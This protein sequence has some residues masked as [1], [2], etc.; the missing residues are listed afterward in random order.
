MSTPVTINGLIVGKVTNIDFA[1]INGS[2]I[3]KFS[4]EKDFEFSKNSEVQI[5]SSGII[6]GNNLGIIPKKDSAR[7]AVSGDTLKGVIQAGLIDGLM[8]K[9]KP[10]ET[11]LL[12][13][14]A[15]LDTVLVSISEVM[16]EETK[17]NLKSSIANLNQTM[18]SFK[19]MSQNMNSL[20]NSN[21]DKLNN[22]FTNL[23]ITAANFARLSDSLAQI[24]TGELVKNMEATLSKLNSIA[25]G[26]DRGEGP[27]GKLLKDEEL[28]D[29]LAGATKQLEL[30]LEDLKLNPK[31]Y[32]H[33]SLFG[34]KP[35]Q[36]E[37]PQDTV[38]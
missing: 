24:K 2:L 38:Q 33:F 27:I 14:L 22:T 12:H 3:V 15:S 32:M 18:A 5:Y 9:F 19:G 10:L 34:K 36:Y 31:R 7:K 1:D 6:S 30:L 20:L 35:K 26:I 29:N 13:T 16:D 17:N 8:D 28:Y 4:V 11:S 21:K 37:A 25:D 23:D